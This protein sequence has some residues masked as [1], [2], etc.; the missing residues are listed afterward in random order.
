MKYYLSKIGGNIS[1]IEYG[2]NIEIIL[3]IPNNGKELFEEN[4][5]NLP[6]LIKNYKIL[7]QKNGYISSKSDKTWK[8]FQK[9]IAYYQKRVYNSKCKKYK[10][11]ILWEEL[12]WKR[13]F[14]Y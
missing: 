9:T 7:K 10:K 12:F 5:K 1:N 4:Y 3:E 6:F 2:N 8:N 13:K 11:F 14:Q